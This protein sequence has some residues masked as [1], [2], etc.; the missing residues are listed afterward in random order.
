MTSTPTFDARLD[1]ADVDILKKKLEDQ[2]GRLENSTVEMEGEHPY[3]KIHTSLEQSLS[4][5]TG[6]AL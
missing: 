2:K 4:D 3:L 5:V 6:F 1:I